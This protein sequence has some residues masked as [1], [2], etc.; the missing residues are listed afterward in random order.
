MVRRTTKLFACILVTVGLLSACTPEQ[1]A[2]IQTSG[3]KLNDGQVTELLALPD[4][5][6]KLP[7]GDIVHPNGTVTK[8]PKDKVNSLP[9]S[10]NFAKPALEAFEIVAKYRGHDD[11]W[12]K[13]WK[14]F[15]ND[16]LLLES[17]YCWNVKRGVIMANGGKNCAIKRQGKHSDSGFGQLIRLH[18]KPGAWLCKQEKLCSSQD[19]IANPWNSMTAVVALVE[20]SGSQPWCFNA[21]A[22]RYHNCKL[23]PDR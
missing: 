18:Y 10:H 16:V 15:I 12:V 4:V 9:Y 20:R 17:G 22:R 14:P 1:V 5:P 23:A 8:S 19:I 13:A 3:V 11:A 21:W 2:V 6:G 7:N